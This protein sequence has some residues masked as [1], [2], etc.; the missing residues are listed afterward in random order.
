MLKLFILLITS[1]TFFLYWNIRTDNTYPKNI[2][3][4]IGDGMGTA[5]ISALAAVN[6]NTNFERFQVGGLLKTSSANKY[7]T[8]SAAGGT[9]YACGVK[10]NNKFLALSPLKD[11]LKTVVEYAE[12][13]G[14]SSGLVVTCQMVHATPASF[15]AHVNDRYN[16]NEIARQ[17]A[18]SNLDVF[19]GG[20]REYFI[21]QSEPGSKREDALDLL[22][23]IKNKMPVITT[24]DGFKTLGE[25]NR[26]AYLYSLETPGKLKDRPFSLKEMTEKALQVLSR[27]KKGFFLMVEGSQIDWGGHDNDIDY[28]LSEIKDFDEALAA[29][30]DFAGTNNETLVIVTADHETGG[31]ILDENAADEQKVFKAVFSSEHHTG[32]MVPVFAY[33][34][35][36]EIFGGIHENTFVG[37]QMILFNSK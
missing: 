19:I 33:G 10:T 26:F 15:A 27:N 6:K 35:Q 31:L 29:G 3:L 7:V 5:Q 9:A 30:L 36:A 13:M 2:I 22:A 34:V 8:D 11:T 12:E 24:R 21:P 16:Y 17:M 32:A 1:I 23:V 4:F 18:Y 14:R 28:M 25:V 20:A 37:Q